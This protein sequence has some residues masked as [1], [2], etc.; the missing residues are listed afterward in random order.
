MHVKYPTGWTRTEKERC[1]KSDKNDKEKNKEKIEEKKN[2]KKKKKKKKERKKE[3]KKSKEK[4][5]EKGKA[6]NCHNP[7]ACLSSR[8]ATVVLYHVVAG[9]R[10]KHFWEK[11]D[12]CTRLRHWRRFRKYLCV[13]KENY[14]F[15]IWSTLELLSVDRFLPIFSSFWPRNI[16]LLR[17]FW[18]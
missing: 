8:F 7:A 10:D 6:A 13:V 4:E 14:D 3:R 17:T 18:H 15:T 2:K 5:K 11:S 9:S 12:L 1:K 16:L